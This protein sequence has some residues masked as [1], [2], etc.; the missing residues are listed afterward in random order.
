MLADGRRLRILC[1]VDDCTRECLGLVA[2]TSL[3]GLRVARELD[4][5]VAVRGLPLTVVSDN[6]FK[7]T[8]LGGSRCDQFVKILEQYLS[9]HDIT[10]TVSL[11]KK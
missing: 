9:K 8:I 2:D 6:E 1:V 4:A 11:G 7:I 5:I 3:P 10:L